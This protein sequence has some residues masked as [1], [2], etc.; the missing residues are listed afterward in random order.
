MPQSV[1]LIKIFLIKECFQRCSA[2]GLHEY[3][4]PFAS[5]KNPDLVVPGIYC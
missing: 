1:P 2:T 3:S 4:S 5:S